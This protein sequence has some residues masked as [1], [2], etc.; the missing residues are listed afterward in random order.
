MWM[1]IVGPSILIA[2]V[3]AKNQHAMKMVKYDVFGDRKW[4]GSQAYGSGDL[5]AQWL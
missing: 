3:M 5:T 1:Q 4:Q 2:M